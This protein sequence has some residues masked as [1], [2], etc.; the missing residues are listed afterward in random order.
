MPDILPPQL[1][2]VQQRPLYVKVRT[3]LTVIS[4]IWLL[5][6]ITGFGFFSGGTTSLALSLVLLYG[7]GMALIVVM[8]AVYRLVKNSAVKRTE[9]APDDTA[10]VVFVDTA[11]S[12]SE[13]L[14]AALRPA[15][16]T[17]RPSAVSTRT[18]RAAVPPAVDTP[19]VTTPAAKASKAKPADA[20]P[21][22]QKQPAKA[23]KSQSATGTPAASTKTAAVAKGTAKTGT[24]SAAAQRV[25]PSQQKTGAA[26]SAPKSA[27]N[28]AV[29]N[30][31][32]AGKPGPGKTAPVK[33]GPGKASVKTAQRTKASSKAPQGRTT[34]AKGRPANNS[35]SVSAA[36]KRTAGSADR[37]TGMKQ[38]GAKDSSAGPVGPV[39][40]I[41]NTAQKSTRPA[42]VLASSN[43]MPQP[44][45][46]HV[47]DSRK[48]A[49]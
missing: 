3:A 32:T 11:R 42:L 35:G 39:V 41:C 16:A 40:Q 21:Q 15:A 12:A 6:A 9:T 28:K 48:R 27:L 8:A 1:V 33:S 31:N 25:S 7:T 17:G 22:A 36:A 2:G 30:K 45:L 34:Q 37:Q 43:A 19:A 24:T 44:R 47:P 20:K 5:M 49:S 38:P 14:L 23:T 46:Q 26:K 10:A 13:E 18:V 4:S 29:P